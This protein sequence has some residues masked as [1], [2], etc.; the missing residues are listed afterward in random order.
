MEIEMDT[1]KILLIFGKAPF[2]AIMTIISF[3][4]FVGVYWFVTARAIEPYY[5]AGLIFAVPFIFFGIIT[6][7]TVT[8]K[9]E[10]I[11]SYVITCV[12]IFLLFFGEIFAFCFL[13]IDAATTTTTDIGKYERVLKFTGYPKDKLTKYFPNKIPDNAKNIVF[14][15]NPAFLQGGE[16]FGLKFEIDSDFINSYIEKL[17]N[18]VKWMG[19]PD[20]DE[21]IENG[22]YSNSFDILGYSNLPRDFTIYLIGSEPYRPNNWNHGKFS[23]VAISRQRNEIIFLAEDW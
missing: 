1:R 15:Y 4:L 7:F 22:I 19:K 21:V 3:V 5:F 9:L 8:G 10:V 23:L 18:K 6:F 11:I 17:S 13:V 12:L 2:Q 14:S 20:D 16:I